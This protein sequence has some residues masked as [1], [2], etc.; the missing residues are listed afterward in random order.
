MKRVFVWLFLS[1][2]LMSVASPAQA[3]VD[4][5]HTANNRVGVHI[6]DPNEVEEVAELVNSNGGDW[7]YVTVPLR[8]DDRDRIKW[9]SFFDVA[10]G[11]HLIPIIR[12]ATV[13]TEKGWTKPTLY[14][15]V[16]FANFLN[17]LDWPTKNRY[18]I[19]YNEPNHAREWGGRVDPI[20]YA[21][22][23]YYT[24][25]IFKE[26]SADFFLLPAGLD[27]AAP[28]DNQHMGLYN[29]LNQVFK[30]NPEVLEN[31][32]GWTS[33]SY[34]NPAFSG[35]PWENH[36]QSIKS[37]LCELNYLRAITG[38]KLPVF[39]TETGWSNQALS[40]KTIAEFYR[41]AFSQIWE[42]EQIVTVTPFVLSAATG[43]FVN[44]S[45]QDPDGMPKPQYSAIKNLAKKTGDPEKG[46]EHLARVL[47]EKDEKSEAKTNTLENGLSPSFGGNHSFWDS[48]KF[49]QFL[50]WLMIK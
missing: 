8:A 41:Q 9:Q 34:P 7:G 5:H 43:P 27:A 31:I 48:D 14:D 30:T 42:D 46:I 12:L 33:H 13:M 24:A 32:D 3:I 38:D 16:D 19:I 44:F 35:N 36:C 6:L 23:L 21:R 50:N 4:P 26:R 10:R 11:E 29:F 1:F 28:S 25:E 22:I 37:Y 17:D 15:A 20:D 40:D 47:G 49:K 2:W 45:L 39:I 18:V